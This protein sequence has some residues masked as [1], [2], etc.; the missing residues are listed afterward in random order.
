MSNQT[1]PFPDKA[2][3]VE[4]YQR[5]V[6]AGSSP[7]DAATIADATL[8]GVQLRRRG[9][10][11]EERAALVL[12]CYDATSARLKSVGDA[13]SDSCINPW[14]FGVPTA[15]ALRAHVKEL[16][17]IDLLPSAPVP[18]PDK[19]LLVPAKAPATRLT[20]ID[21]LM[22]AIKKMGDGNIRAFPDDMTVG[23]IITD[24]KI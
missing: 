12:K 4:Y 15:E 18:P 7:A 16:A 19:P 9:I 13:T 23:Q 17:R 21:L 2:L 14:S 5:A 20:H 22:E 8:A 24:S 10:T 11:N 3:W 1:T 6:I